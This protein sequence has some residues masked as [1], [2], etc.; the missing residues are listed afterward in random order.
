MRDKD[1]PVAEVRAAYHRLL[2]GTPAPDAPVDDGV[3]IFQICE[4]YLAK[5]E[6]E[7]AKSTLTVRQN[8]LFDFCVGLPSRFIP[9]RGTERDKPKPDDY[10]HDGYGTMSVGKLRPIHIDQWLQ[11]HPNWNGSRRTQIQAVKRALNYAVEAG[12]IQ[13]NP[14]KGYRTPKQRA[15]VTYIT[16]EQEAALCGAANP[17]LSIAIQVCIRTGAR[18]GCEFARLTAAHV[19]DHGER[20]EWVF[21]PE[22]SKTGHLRT[23]RII[24]PAIKEIVRLQIAAHPR[25]PIFRNSVGKPWAR[26]LLTEKFRVTKN[27]LIKQGMEFDSDCCMYACRH[28]Y[29]KRVL[30]GYWSGKM[31]NIETLAKLMGNSPEICRDHYLQWTDSYTE[32]LWESA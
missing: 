12:L 23:L 15:R 2:S 8:T 4:A 10:F 27:R 21:R 26:E 11:A 13:T 20:M 6:S 3:T 9:G 22:E 32:P 18:P 29:A 24:D 7:G 5:A 1:T 19:K 25:G 16:P 14:I 17:T 28:T 31:V 30:Q